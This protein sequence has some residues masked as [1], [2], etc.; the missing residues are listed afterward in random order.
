MKVKSHLQEHPYFFTNL[1]SDVPNWTPLKTS[2]QKNVKIVEKKEKP[3]KA[4]TFE[5][6]YEQLVDELYEKAAND[7]KLMEALETPK[8]QNNNASI[9]PFLC[10][11]LP[12]DSP[13]QTV[14]E[15]KPSDVSVIAAMGDS[16][17][18][19]NGCGAETVAQV[20]VNNRG[21]S[22]SAGGNQTLET[23]LSLPNLIKKYNPD[24]TGWSWSRE[25]IRDQNDTHCGNA[26]QCSQLNVAVPGA[27][28]MGADMRSQFTKK[29][30]HH[31][32]VRY[33]V[34]NVMQECRDRLKTSSRK[35][36][37]PT[38][39]RATWISKTTGRW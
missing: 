7:P 14:H 8:E 28:N 15:L 25:V 19:C 3:V 21:Y 32:P 35:C 20:A 11:V 24:V 29:Y 31:L 2:T 12:N 23:I 5:E 17:T 38:Q 33:I 10:E 27:V 22:W 9:P 36:R 13:A 4:Q 26:M 18:A 6:H 39:L 16:I 37:T 30:M 1:N 34:S